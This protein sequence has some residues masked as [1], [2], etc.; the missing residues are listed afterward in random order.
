MN[1]QDLIEKVALSRD[2]DTEVRFMRDRVA[3]GL[4]RLPLNFAGQVG[5]MAVGAALGQRSANPMGKFYGAVLGG[6]AAG[7]LTSAAQRQM[8]LNKLSKKYLGEG[9]SAMDMAKIHG[10]QLAAAVLGSKK[11]TRGLAGIPAAMNTPEVVIQKKRQR[12]EAEKEASYLTCANLEKVA[13][14]RDE[15]TETRFMR[16]RF[17]PGLKRLPLNLA[18]TVAGSA[19][20]G[21][22]GS[23]KGGAAAITGSMIGGVLGNTLTAGAQRHVALNK[24]NKKYFNEK[25]TLGDKV[26]LHGTHAASMAVASNP[27]SKGFTPFFTAANTPEAIVQRKRRQQAAQSEE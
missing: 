18:G 20:G 10:T 3:P 4:K 19:M 21:A 27:V 15:D 1:Y 17:V 9:P 5:G 16:D 25:A 13:L 2:E 24:L 12:L 22:L 23:S 26:K 7:Q 6:T 8:A 14:D 11:E